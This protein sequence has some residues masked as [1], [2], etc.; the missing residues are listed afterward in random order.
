MAERV[1][2]LNPGL[3]GVNIFLGNLGMSDE[4]CVIVQVIT[5][6]QTVFH[7]SCG[8]YPSVKDCADDLVSVRE[9]VLPDPAIAARYEKQYRNFKE[10][11]PAL[12]PLFAK[13]QEQ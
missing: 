10:I 6:F 3:C 12:K 7:V 2:F 13:L 4:Y 1:V 8:L 5:V 11:Y 9:T